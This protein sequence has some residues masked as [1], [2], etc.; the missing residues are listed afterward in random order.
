ME[1]RPLLSLPDE[2]L[3]N[4]FGRFEPEP[5][6]ATA[7]SQDVSMLSI[8]KP[9]A[10]LQALCLTSRKC[11]GLTQPLLYHTPILATYAQLFRLLRSLLGNP[12]LRPH[13]R[14]FAFLRSTPMSYVTYPI[15]FDFETV[16]PEKTTTTEHGYQWRKAWLQAWFDRLPKRQLYVDHVIAL[17]I[18]LAPRLTDIFFFGR[19]RHALE[20][21]FQDAARLGIL[22]ELQ[23]LRFRSDR[24]HV[25]DYSPVRLPALLW[26]GVKQVAVI[27]DEGLWE[28]NHVDH[29]LGMQVQEKRNQIEE[30]KL[31]RSNASPSNVG[32]LLCRLPSL[33]VFEWTFQSQEGRQTAH[34]QTPS[35]GRNEALKNASRSLETLHIESQ[36]RYFSGHRAMSQMHGPMTEQ[37][38]C[39]PLFTNLKELTIKFGDL[40][41]HCS[42]KRDPA[43]LPRMSTLLPQSLV[44]L[45]LIQ[46]WYS[47]PLD[48]MRRVERNRYLSIQM[49]ERWLN[50]IFKHLCSD[51]H[52]F[53]KLP[54]LQEFEYRVIQPARRVD[55]P[56]YTRWLSS[57]RKQ[58]S[59]KFKS[60][61]I[62]F[63]WTWYD[64]CFLCR[65]N[66]WCADSP[67]TPES[68]CSSC[69]PNPHANVDKVS[70]EFDQIIGFLTRL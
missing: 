42:Q 35:T 47:Q 10:T 53:Q 44:R 49:N 18:I 52:E 60:I 68:R 2:L 19:C 9:H 28:S 40:F 13:L 33:K 3:L 56:K 36:W 30:L 69:R 45:R 7:N 67:P 58:L 31:L 20:P 34:E 57:V 12:R 55:T 70:S 41:G 38:T 5:V 4:I 6:P 25:W 24:S 61:G 51:R 11:N 17:L 32:H 65:E 1:S 64:H 66:P 48:N 14:N 62:A 15:N 54:N 50:N 39:L 16:W 59:A 8:S 23:S 37:I 21:L 26:P 22:T 27:G 29:H 63:D 46:R 43:T